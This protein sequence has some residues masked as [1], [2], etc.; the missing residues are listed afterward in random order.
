MTETAAKPATKTG[1]TKVASPKIYQAIAAIQGEVGNIPKNGVG[2][3]SQGA[4]KFISNDDII[5]NVSKLLTKHGVVVR[6]RTLDYQQAVREIGPNR[7]I[8]LSIV[9]L[10]TTYISTE[11]GS[12]FSVITVGEGADNGD[13]GA[14]K[15]YT[16]ASKVAN[17]L[18]FSIA[19]G[20]PDPD[21]MDVQSVAAAAPKASAAANK[22]SK[23][24]TN[25]TTL[26]N[27]IKAFLGANGLP[28]SVANSLGD[29]LSG[30]KAAAEWS[31]DEAVLTQILTALKNGE[32]E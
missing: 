16:Q 23:A 9:T 30:G 28:G 32:V 3:A 7:G 21:S 31:Q 4:Y 12:E 25:P 6:S 17:L 20:E 18:T 22:V 24:R 11:D 15:A 29:R 19:T 8:A 10:E 27:E 13:K 1:G 14:R 26:F 2:P 5:A